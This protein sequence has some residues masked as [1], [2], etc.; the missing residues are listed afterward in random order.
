[1]L[2]KKQRAETFAEAAALE[3]KPHNELYHQ[4]ALPSS[5]KLKGQ[6]GELLLH[7]QNPLLSKK[8]RQLD[9]KLFEQSLRQYL[10]VKDLGVTVCVQ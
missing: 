7:L 10:A 1:M 6:I 8:E 2:S 5:R 9:W 4:R 3:N